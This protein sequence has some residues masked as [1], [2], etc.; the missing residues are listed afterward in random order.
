M[1]FS[2]ESPCEFVAGPEVPRSRRAA[3]LKKAFVSE[4]RSDRNSGLLN[5]GLFVGE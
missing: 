3:G 1:C 4:G 5:S 2:L